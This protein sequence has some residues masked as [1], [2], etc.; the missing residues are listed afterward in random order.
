MPQ[1]GELSLR[2]TARMTCLLAQ[3]RTVVTMW[4]T[5]MRGLGR[6]QVLLGTHGFSWCRDRQT[7]IKGTEVDELEGRKTD[8]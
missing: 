3:A 1:S 8:R 7:V 4:L 6:Q 5:Y 2:P